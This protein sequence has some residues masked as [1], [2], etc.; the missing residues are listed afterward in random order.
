[1]TE[2]DGDHPGETGMLSLVIAPMQTKDLTDVVAIEE[3]VFPDPWSHRL[4]VEELNQRTSRAY[5]SAWAGNRLVGF[6]G[7]MFID[8]EAHV[9]NIAVDPAY[10]GRWIGNALM[11]D[12]VKTVIGRGARHLTLEVRVGNMPALALYSKF[13]LAP[14]GIRPNYY[15]AGGDALVMWVRDIDTDPYESRVVALAHAL[16]SRVDLESRW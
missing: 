13:G 1:M 15:P 10:Q 8:D 3:K 2:F 7:V 6:A 16:A 11:L 5:R 12:L 9:N 14:V 4:F